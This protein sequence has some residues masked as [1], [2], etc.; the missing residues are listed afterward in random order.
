LLLALVVIVVDAALFF[1]PL[2][3]LFLAYVILVNPPGFRECYAAKNAR[4]SAYVSSGTSSA[5]KCPQS[6]QRPRTSVAH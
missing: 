2:S 4:S 1:L 3:A 6:S 5:R